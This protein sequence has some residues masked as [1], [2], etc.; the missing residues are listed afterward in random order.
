MIEMRCEY[1]SVRCIW[2]YVVKLHIWRL[3][4]ASIFLPFRWTIECRFT[5]KFVRNMI[6]TY[7]QYRT[8]VE[9]KEAFYIVLSK[10][11]LVK[12][13][14]SNWNLADVILGNTTVILIARIRNVIY[15]TI[16]INCEGTHLWESE[17]LREHMNNTKSSTG[18]VMC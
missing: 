13:L 12:N 9:P 8:D 1:L 18:R 14:Y 10:L 6:I 11:I 3:L 16:C 15:L 4:R 5:L 2:L 7:S 17:C